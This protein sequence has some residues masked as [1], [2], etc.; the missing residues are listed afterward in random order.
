M[1]SMIFGPAMLPSFVTCP[2]ISVGTPVALARYVSSMQASRSWLTLPGAA[3]R[4][5]L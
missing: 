4:S 3:A 5:G 1:C 2:T